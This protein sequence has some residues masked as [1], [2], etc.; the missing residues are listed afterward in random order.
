MDDYFRYLND[1]QM[2]NKVGVDHQLAGTCLF[3]IFVLQPS[4]TRPFPIKNNGHLGS[5]YTCVCLSKIHNMDVMTR[6][7]FSPKNLP[8]WKDLVFQQLNYCW[9]KKSCTSWYGEYPMFHRVLYATGGAGFLPSTVPPWNYHPE[10][11]PSPREENGFPHIIFFQ[12][13]ERRVKK[14]EKWGMKTKVTCVFVKA[15]FGKNA[16]SPKSNMFF[17]VSRNPLHG[18][19]FKHILC[20]SLF[21]LELSVYPTSFVA[22]I[23][24]RMKTQIENHLDHLILSFSRR[25]R[26]WKHEN[27]PLGRPNQGVWRNSYPWRI[28]GTICIFT[29]HECLIFMANAGEYTI[30]GSYGISKMMYLLGHPAHL[31][32]CSIHVPFKIASKWAIDCG[33]FAQPAVTVNDWS[34]APVE[35]GIF[36]QKM[37]GGE[38]WT[39]QSFHIFKMRVS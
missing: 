33:W 27:K 26:P 37:F 22:N 15:T 20:I 30:H 32:Q 31:Q 6:C 38:I 25:Y 11:S 8:T 1:E 10:T 4:K 36:F 17:S 18:S 5:G 9:W 29:W 13:G 39:I 14:D 21:G 23:F 24:P 28:H 12:T 3:S 35:L 16:C 19:S 34:P 7:F 2:T